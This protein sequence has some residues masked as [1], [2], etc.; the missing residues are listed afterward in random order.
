MQGPAILPLQR[1]LLEVGGENLQKYADDLGFNSAL[2]VDGIKTAKGK[3]DVKHADG[4]DLAWAGIGQYSDTVNP[5]NFMAYMGAIANNGVRVTPTLQKKSENKII[6]LFP[7]IGK[8]QN[9][10]LS[11]ETAMKIKQLMRNDV[12]SEYGENNFKGLELCAKTGTAEVGGNAAPHS[13]FAGFLDR[14]DYPLAFVVVVENGGSG[15]SAAGS[16]AAKVLKT[17]VEK[18]IE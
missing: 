11:E 17:A 7:D 14:T 4:G 16:V 5:L 12:V 3:V 2:S 6:S 13:W 10:I 1:F 8:K 18:R 9:N 15:I